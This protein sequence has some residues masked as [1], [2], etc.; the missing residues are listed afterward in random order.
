MYREPKVPEAGVSVEECLD[1][2]ARITSKE[3]A[4][5]HSVNSGIH[6]YACST[7]RR[8][9][10]DLVKSALMCTARLKNSLA[11]C[12][13]RMVT[14]VQWLCWKLH[15]NWVAY[16]KLWSRRSLHPFYGRAQTYGN[17]SDHQGRRTF[18][19]KIHR[20]EWLAQVILIRVTPVLQNL[21]IGLRKRRNGESD[22]P[23]K[24][25]GGWLKASWN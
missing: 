22:V 24:Q 16:F 13:K 23:V 20:L 7:S 3:L 19:T 10:A 15:D 8:M 14:K 1:G 25:R 6:Q 21:R 4:P 9:D 17:R 2:P 18:E 5:V 12:L 11:K